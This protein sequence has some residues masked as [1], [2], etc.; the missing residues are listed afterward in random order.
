[1]A[2]QR[3][4]ITGAMHPAL[5]HLYRADARAVTTAGSLREWLSIWLRNQLLIP[6]L[7]TDEGGGGF[8]AADLQQGEYGVLAGEP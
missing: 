8:V 1:M 2:L 6:G 5:R 7:G 3:V 4:A